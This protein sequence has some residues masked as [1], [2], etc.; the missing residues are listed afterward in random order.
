MLILHAIF[1]ININLQLFTSI[2]SLIA[3]TIEYRWLLFNLNTNYIFSYAGTSKGIFNEKIIYRIIKQEI[4]I[5]NY[6][7]CT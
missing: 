4:A 6:K 7:C 5:L 3:S 1:G 2:Q